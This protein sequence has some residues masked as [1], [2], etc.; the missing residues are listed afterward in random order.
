MNCRLRKAPEANSF[1]QVKPLF[2]LKM[3]KKKQIVTKHD[4]SADYIG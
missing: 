4:T 3:N 1:Q 2:Y